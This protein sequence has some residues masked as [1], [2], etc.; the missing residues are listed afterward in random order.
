MFIKRRVLAE[1]RDHLD[2]P[3]ISLVVGPRQAGK[4][5]LL[6][7]L[8]E[9]LERKG[10]KTVFFNLDREAD[11]AAF[12]SQEVFLRRIRLELGEG[13]GFVFV[14]EIQRKEDAGW[15]LKG[16]YDS[17]LP[18]KLI[19]SGS[20]SLELKE[21]IK[22]SLAGRKLMFRVNTLSFAEWLGFKTEWRYEGREEEFFRLEKE[23]AW[24][25]LEE[26][27]VF[28]GYPRVVL[29]ESFEEKER[30]IEEIFTSYLEKDVR[31]LLGVRGEEAFVGL[32]RL[33]AAVVGRPVKYS[34]LAGE[35]GAAAATLR[36]YL[37]YLEKTFVV[38]A[39]RPFFTNPAK[40]LRKS[41]I[42]Y[43]NDLGL[44]SFALG[45]FG[46]MLAGQEGFWFQ[47]WF[48]L[49]LAEKL[50]YKGVRVGFWRSKDK[51]EVD[52]VLERGREVVPIEV[53]Y[54]SWPE[55][56]VSRSL[57]SFIRRY[58][59]KRAYVVNRDVEGEVRVE[60]TRVGVWP[61]WRWVVT[62]PEE[63]F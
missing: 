1:L 31:L 28:G 40:E 17:R 36:R 38:E 2:K 9:E 51:A 61:Y 11:R 7:K 8:Q 21:K 24:R 34:R 55:G 47:N 18:Y 41:P 20:G 63:W 37:W 49:V 54:G 26:Y 3:E 25:W 10:E 44:L 45:S 23:R 46:R 33:L 39:V 19:V 50:R 4:T 62:G 30:L 59:P 32:V 6:L 43:F 60:G 57:L 35:L 14:D 5:T 52:F 15:F 42:F 12:E 27:L 16:V 58:R 22:E 48:F 56:R 29:A 53:K 13:R